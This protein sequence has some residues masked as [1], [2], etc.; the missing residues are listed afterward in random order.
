MYLTKSCYSKDHVLKRGTVKLGTLDHYRRTEIEHIADKN[1]G[2]LTFDLQIR[3]KTWIEIKWLNTFQPNVLLGGPAD[4][5]VIFEGTTECQLNELGIVAT[6]NSHALVDHADLFIKREAPNALIFCMSSGQTKED[7]LGI[8]PQYD[9]QWH[10]L[11]DSKE[12]LSRYFGD[13]L[14][15]IILTPDRGGLIDPTL[16]LSDLTIHCEC[17]SV[18]Y[19]SRHTRFDEH[20]TIDINE[21]L[22]LMSTMS[23]IKPTNYASER[24]YRFSFHIRHRGKALPLLKDHAILNLS[25]ECMKLI[26]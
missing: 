5:P 4:S 9:D 8:F 15:E 7:C 11:K 17:R 13:S 14:R 24:E 20:T 25:E 6:D 23:F 1:E 10:I 3:R 2:Q 19:A 22:Q 16:S 12:I 21:F 26:L 18:I